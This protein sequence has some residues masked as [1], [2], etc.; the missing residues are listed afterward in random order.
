MGD[1]Y[2]EKVERILTTVSHQEPDK[3]PILSMFETWSVS[4]ANSTIKEME[5]NPEKE[6]E[7]YSKPHGDVYSDAAFVSGLAFDAKSARLIGCK[8]HFISEDGQTV[9]HTEISPM[10]AEE[11]SELV[12]DPMGYMF[13]TMVPRKAEKLSKGYPENYNA[14]KDLVNHWKFKSAAQ[15][16]LLEV[17]KNKYNMPVLSSNIAYP[18][19]DI[20]FD[21][22]RGFKGISMDLRRNPDDLLAG[23][24]ALEEFANQIMGIAP[25]AESVPEFPFYATMMHVPT[26]INPKQFEK[27]FWPTYERMFNRIHQLGGKL[28]MFL[29]GN[30]ESKYE[31]LNSMPKNFAI[32]ILEEDNVFNA[33]KKIGDNI[34]LAGGMPLNMLKYDNKEKCID[35]AKRLVDECAP[36]GGYIFTSSRALLSKDDLNVENL[37]AVNNYVHEYGIY[38]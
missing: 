1:T 35:Y 20:I 27:Y 15:G 13:N 30:W 24:N 5:D 23:I 29:E 12:K 38:K 6:I 21:Y 36:G 4:Y 22:L 17:L 37:I 14:I 3:V 19:M 33:K 34:T 10:R 16:K 9:Q 25:D 7:I 8:G 28:V 18:P 2:Q 31:F 32:G 26:F 11:Y